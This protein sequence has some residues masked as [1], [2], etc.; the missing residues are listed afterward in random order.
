MLATTETA[1]KAAKGNLLRYDKTSL[2]ADH[3][4]A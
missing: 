3:A 4:H 2:L 1:A